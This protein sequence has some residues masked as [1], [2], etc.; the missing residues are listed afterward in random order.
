[1]SAVTASQIVG[2]LTVCVLAVG[3]G[4]IG[5]LA[6]GRARDPHRTFRVGAVVV[7]VGFALL[8]VYL[9]LL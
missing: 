7:G 4:F 5:L 2:I 8:L 3:V 9:Y 1:M 6:F